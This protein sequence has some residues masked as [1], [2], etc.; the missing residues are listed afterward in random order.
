MLGTYANDGSRSSTRSA[1][2][3]KNGMISTSHPLASLAGLDMLRSGGSAVDA[4]IAAAT[5]LGVVEPMST[6]IGGDLFALVYD[7]DAG[8][9]YGLNASGRSAA[10]AT[11]QEFAKRGLEHIPGSGWL[12]VTVPGSVD[13]L[14]QLSKRFGR[15]EWAEL[16]APA[17]ELANGG[18]VVAPIVGEMWQE[19]ERRLSQDEGMAKHYLLDGRAPRAGEVMSLPALGKS[20]EILA[21][22][23]RDAFYHGWI[24][25]EIAKASLTHDGFLELNDLA[26]HTS[27]WVDPISFDYRGH[28]VYE[29][30]PNGQGLTALISLNILAKHNLNALGHNSADALHLL[31]ESLK[32]AF[33]DRDRYITDPEDVNIPLSD[34]LSTTYG[35]KRNQEISLTEA[36]RYPLRQTDMGRPFV[37][38]DTVYLCAIDKW[39]N[40]A[41]LITSIAASFGAGVVAGDTGII[42]QNR[43]ASFSLDEGHWNC[44]KPR[45]RTMHTIIPA[46]LAELTD[47]A[48]PQPV[49]AFGVMGGDMQPQGHVQ[50]VSNVLDH[51]MNIQKALDA[52]RLRLMYDG[53][54]ALEHGICDRVA[55]DLATRGQRL[56]KPQGVFFGSGQAVEIDLASGVLIGGADHRRDGCALGY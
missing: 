39:G 26:H 3:A 20:L 18:F 37:P 41:S 25:E 34:L 30:P 11:C 50:F 5:V 4:V 54:I 7:A 16:F 6:G 13:G 48:V 51:G 53:K 14:W 10:R 42:M 23:G 24:A 19:A 2:M 40:M 15:L 9:I 1:V 47:D 22:E 32:V 27:D 43:G 46:I 29:L 12:C 52:P 44:L 31:A 21:R 17:I 28:R 55:L 36:L 38:S 35:E 49:A 33:S 8:G 45:K 56:A